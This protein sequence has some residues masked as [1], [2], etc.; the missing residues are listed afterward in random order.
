MSAS[1]RFELVLTKLHPP[2]LA[3]HLLPRTRLFAMLDDGLRTPL[4][5]VSA[6]AGYGKSTLVASWLE[7]TDHATAWVSFDE[8]DDSLATVLSYML[9]AIHRAV[10][11][12]GTKT[13]RTLEGRDRPA[14]PELVLTLVNDL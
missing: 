4:T 12:V 8:S 14:V 6:P 5:L 2:R 1:D 10:P 9:E 7:T 11:G 3:V 13:R